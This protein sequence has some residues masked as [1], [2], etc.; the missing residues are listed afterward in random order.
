MLKYI[1]TNINFL[2]G[3]YC[4]F[5]VFSDLNHFEYIAIKMAEIMKMIYY[6]MLLVIIYQKKT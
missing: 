2:V 3:F 5:S 1:S 6:V 4:S